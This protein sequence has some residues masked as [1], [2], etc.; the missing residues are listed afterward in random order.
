MT[1][2]DSLLIVLL[3]FSATTWSQTGDTLTGEIV[4]SLGAV[5]PGATVQLE[6]IA[7]AVVKTATTDGSGR[8]QLPSVAGNDHVLSVSR[9]GFRTVKTP[10][11]IGRQKPLSIVLPVLAADEQITVGAESPQV[12]TESAGNR[13]S[14]EVGAKMLEQLPVV[15]Q[16]YISTLSMFLDSGSTGTGGVSLVVDGME[17]SRLGVSSSAIQQI[18]I[19]NDPYAAE[20]FRPGRGR[21][22]VITKPAAPEYHGAFNFIFRDSAFS[23]A[24]AFASTKPDEQRRAYEGFFTGPIA[25]SKST[26]FQVSIARQELDN[27]AVVFA[28]G[29]SGPIRDNVAAPQR[30]TDVSVRITHVFNGRHSANIDYSLE[31]SG[32][33]NRGVGGVVLGIAGTRSFSQEHQWGF[34]DTLTIT[35]HLL[36]QFQVRYEKNR[37]SVTSMS[38]D[39]K[40][41]VTDAFTSGGAQV[42]QRRTESALHFNEIVTWTR[43]RQT[44]KAGVNVPNLSFRSFD[45]RSNFG[46]TYYF[47]SLQ[48]YLARQPFSYTAQQ[49]NGF[50][51]YGQVEIGGFFQDEIRLRPDFSIMAGMRYDWQNALHD[52]NNVAPRLSFA[53]APE[54]KG[55]LVVRGGV[56]V[57]YDRTGPGPLADLIRYDG[58]H[59]QSIVLTNPSYPDPFAGGMSGATLPSNIVKLAPTV[60]IPYTMQYGVSIERQLTKGSTLSASYRGTEG[61]DLFRSRDI[62]APL[63]P[64]YSGRPDREFGTIRQIESTGSQVG[65]AL[66]ISVKGRINRKI[67]GMGQY[68]LS[69]TY[70]DTDGISYFPANSVNPS[71][72]WGRANFDQRHRVNLLE[73]FELGKFVNLGVGLRVYSGAPFTVMTGLDQNADG[74]ANERPS[75]VS[76]N[77][78]HGPGYADVDLR[79]FHD[80]KLTRGKKEGVPTI[81]T[82][83]DAFNLFNTAIYPT[84]VGNLSSPFFGRPVSALDPRRL[85]FTARIKF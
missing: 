42:D 16:D 70:N 21:V 29:V 49:G 28:D 8:F 19:N 57:F 78:A 53:Y 36:N 59:L 25:R 62:N 20:Y 80:F 69:K 65:R 81:T 58:F 24:N 33:T 7:G 23:A 50:I 41:V 34:T 9:N 2:F 77:S 76:R 48:S 47:S 38:S 63:P 32:S 3:I 64:F 14:V 72:E 45:D 82:A 75:G 51:N 10:L 66:E 55:K 46:G 43:N 85:Q 6:T 71:G 56:G 30:N 74:F 73:T 44:I 5:I 35:P 54:K 61:I 68:T 18:K 1:R 31:Q 40:I 4:D 52:S 79:W 17:A 84:F 37:D 67:T 60:H 11:V 15:D 26:F 83:V 39:G 12:S 13:D 27:Q 22:E